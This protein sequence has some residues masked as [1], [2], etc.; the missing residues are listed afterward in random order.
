MFALLLALSASPETNQVVDVDGRSYR[1]EVNG[2]TVRV[3]QKAVFTKVSLD[4][5]SR[6]RRAVTQATG[7]RI[8]DDYWKE[9]K[10]EGFLDCAR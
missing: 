6:M 1:V 9:T 3:F 10:L 4:A 8:V 5:R 2:E 7:C